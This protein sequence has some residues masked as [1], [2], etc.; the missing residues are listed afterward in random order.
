MYTHLKA[1]VIATLLG[2]GVSAHEQTPAYLKK[3]YS[4]VDGIVKFEL[5]IFNSREEVKYYQIGVFDKNFVGLPFSSKYRIMKVEYKTRVNFDVYVRKVDLD[6][7]MY[8]CTKSKLL[9]DN[10]SK[11]FVSSLICSKIMEKT[12]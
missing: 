4:T 2:S 3:Q 8:I 6:R 1:L 7:A 10:K 9:K 5:S 11:P 12:K